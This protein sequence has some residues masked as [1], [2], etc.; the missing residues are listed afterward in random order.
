MFV[1]N[2][3]T[4]HPVTVSSATKVD[5]AIHLLKKHNIRRLPV[6]DDGKLVGIVTDKDLMRVT[7]SAATTLAKYEINSLLAG[8]SIGEI[9]SKSVISVNESAPIEE[10]ALLMSRNR[11][12]GLPV[13]SDVGAVVGVIT[14]TDIF[15]AFVN[16]M[17]LEEGKTRITLEVAD[18]VGVVC[19]LAGICRKRATTST[20]SSPAAKKAASMTSSCGATLKTRTPWPPLWPRMDTSSSTSAASATL[21][22]IHHRII[23]FER[24]NREE[25]HRMKEAVWNAPEPTGLHARTAGLL[26]KIVMGYKAR[27]DVSANGRA[28][29][30]RSL[31]GLMGL[32]ASAGTPLTIRAEGPE[33]EQVL[34]AI[35]AFLTG[36]PLS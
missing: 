22:I 2:R 16:I 10:A 13:T 29:D 30:G 35:G 31:L 36:S 20:A 14:E 1:V 19:D 21:E 25:A 15:D 33:E 9:M 28:A 17:D 18:K 12:S 8:I 4:K 11:V 27:V 6:V 32:G 3:M 5:E 34:S 23:V 7:P 24:A 26:M